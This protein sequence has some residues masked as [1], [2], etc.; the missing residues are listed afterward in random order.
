MFHLVQSLYDSWNAREEYS[1]LILGLDNAGKTTL[2]E[3]VKSQ[4][5]T[6]Y[7]KLPPSRI[8]PT[9]GQN[10]ATIKV[11]KVNLKFWDVGGQDTLREL[12]DE[13]YEK[14]HAIVFVIDSC[15]KDRLVEC[16]NALTKIV[17]NDL[18]EGLPILM[19]ANKQDLDS[20][21]KMELADIKEIFNPIAANLNARD[22][23]VLPVSAITGDGVKDSIDWLHVRLIRNKANRPPKFRM[24]SVASTVQQFR[25]LFIQTQETPNENAL[26]FIPNGATILPSP[27]TPT[28]EIDGI[29]DALQ[30]SELAFKLLSINNKCISS[31][32][33]GY[34]FM[35]VVKKTA[36]EMGNGKVEEWSVLKP[37]IFS[38]L[39]EHLTMGRPILTEKYYDYLADKLAA[40]KQKEVDDEA[41]I[42]EEEIEGEEDAEDEVENLIQ[43]LLTT[44]IQPA[45]QEDGGD[46]K[47][48]KYDADS[49]TVY[50][51]LIGA[52]KSCS[53]SE[54]TLKNGIEE[55][56]KYYIDEVKAVKQ[57]IEDASS[58]DAQPPQQQHQEPPSKHDEYDEVPP[59]L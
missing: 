5:I 59:T 43:E 51:K 13:Y 55:M 46:I 10:V 2:L 6:S 24:L 36:R 49:G 40:Q 33:L 22:S 56:L 57:V 31:I 41:A 1:V 42:E 15:D 16:S 35:T 44:R 18:A 9:M 32:L 14:A 3:E 30:K 52:C 20:P 11:N 29:K 27:K 17:T 26:K 50:L 39:T 28:V 34:G 8:L 7:K 48:I 25:S 45:I 19:L 37:Q 21:D 53:S 54:V 12:W 4:Y 47:F 23:R 38:I 58:S